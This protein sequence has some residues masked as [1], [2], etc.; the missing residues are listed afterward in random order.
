M[1][2]KR[3]ELHGFKSFADKT[4]IPL[5]DGF[6]AIIGPNG[7]GKSNVAEA[8]RWTL[9]EQS[10]KS[11]RGK[12][13]QDVIF[14]GTE[15][16]RSM[17][18]SEVTL[19]FDNSD[20]HIFSTLP[21][22]EVSITR[23]LDRSGLSEYYINNTRCRMKDIISILHDTGIGKEGYSI[24]GQGR[25]DE[26]L[27]AKP[28]DRRNIF[29][30]AAGISKFRAQRVE[31]ERKLE[32]TALNLQT[33]N[34]V[35][36]E[37]EKQITPL[38]RQAETA[39]KWF[40]LKSALKKQ[41]VNL[42][43]Y[44]YENNESIKKK[45]YDRI[46]ETNRQ[47]QAKELAY[48]GAVQDYESTLRE[49]ALLDQTYDAENAELLS[50]KVDA[51]KVTG[52]V[53]VLK[54]RISNYQNEQNRLNEELKSVDAQLVISAELIRNCEAK[55]EEVL[56]EYMAISKDYEQRN[57]R[58]QL[59]SRSIAGGESDLET[60][61]AEYIAAIKEL[62]DLRNNSSA[63]I[64][65]K[66]VNEERAKNLL[67]LINEK[68]AKLDEENTSLS[69]TDANVKARRE[70]LR[71]ILQECNETLSEKADA[72]E[73]IKGIN[74]DEVNLNSK[75]G[76]IESQLK[77][78]ISAKDEYSSYQE[79][80]KR[81]MGDAKHD[82]MLQSKILGVMA[83][84]LVVPK[85]YES[86]IEYALG[87]NM[88]NV[89]VE[90][91]RD[92]GALITH[93][94]QKN[95]GRITFRPRTAC[96]RRSLQGYEREALSEQGCLGVAA[97]L[98]K[99]EPKFDDFVSALLGNVVIVDNMISAERIWKKYDRSFKIVTLDGEVYA[100][101]GEVTGGSRRS[102]TSG[103]LSQEA[104]IEQH[105]QNL[106]RLLRNLD[107]LRKQREDRA[108]DIE[109][110]EETLEKLNARISELR[111]EIT[112]N[113]DKSKQSVD[114]IEAL[115]KEIS[116]QAGEYELVKARVNELTE[117]LSSIDEL[118]EL[119]KSREAEYD[120]LVA[121]QKTESGEKKS[122]RDQLSEEVMNLRVKIAQTKSDLDAFDSEMFRHRR[123]AE[124]LEQ[125]KL[126]YIAQIKTVEN[127]LN[128]IINAPERTSFSDA[129]LKRIKELEESIGNLSEKKRTTAD[130]IRELDAM[131]NTLLDE[132]NALS[133]K[134]IRDEG[135]L[136]RIDDENRHLQEHVLEEYD[137]TYTSALEFKDE[138]FEIHGAKTIIS[139]L[140]KDIARLGNV[141]TLAVQDLEEA[142]KRHAEQV[143]QRD[144]IQAAYNDIFKIIE[145]LTVE[146]TGKFTSAF[147]KIQVNFKDVFTKLFGGGKGELRLDTTETNDPLEAG[148]E[149]YA[150]PPGKS[151]KHISLLSGGERAVTAIAILFSI[152]SLKP[153][154]FC[155]LDEI[156]AALDESNANLFAEFITKFSDY[157]QFIVITHRKP[158]MR[159][160]DS[161]FGVTME[162]R[163]VTKIV[164]IEF[165][166]A[167]KA[168][169]GM[170]GNDDLAME[171]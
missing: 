31:A 154:P 70:E 33:A 114:I 24:I 103:L 82:P 109:L 87:G 86:A 66:G 28:E 115:S 2:L 157:T 80:I 22:D 118:E 131:K 129:D 143:V 167:V 133:E 26:I 146:M 13:M 65:E 73:A 25:I 128:N 42:Y 153:M 99:C 158:T 58:L 56:Q 62:G 59:I 111:I 55:K 96:K 54:E 15:K 149:I 20:Q 124:A 105:K 151:L 171:A 90:N 18:Y 6:T 164:A 89:L 130:R 166:E 126:D 48:N 63:Y 160:A 106:D 83:E 138:E 12:S 52:Q 155:V 107:S 76:Y 10:A 74:E 71:N 14:A 21:Y 69:I 123:D 53:N 23:K 67:A 120:T 41:E 81:L 168:T 57:E 40:E 162:E 50:L 91:E 72:T 110:Y 43:I 98:V 97:D 119:V 144:D 5:K 1:N 19:V 142:E 116:Q 49:S 75:R 137:L 79:S 161:I 93:L 108:R 44:N 148:I 35:I 88:Q 64:Q 121:L 9:G 3:I 92:A 84:V 100:R 152:L 122:E 32:K 125:E 4:P 101:G 60:K 27:S 102:A 34:E 145:E 37:I 95:Y 46:D 16:R 132:K 29:E 47:L 68:K 127:Q 104:Q 150:Q 135:M 11:L 159:H 94:K 7:C 8:I 38:R 17:S 170:D 165:E 36:A 51:E 136:E 77:L 61:N 163:G 117:K 112:L 45:V 78:A 140:K 141:N 156:D 30:E 147:E 85:E 134:K 39:K 169:A 113:E 139:D